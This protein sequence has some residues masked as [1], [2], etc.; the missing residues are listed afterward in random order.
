M[1]KE[2]N[3]YAIQYHKRDNKEKSGHEIYLAKNSEQDRKMFKRDFGK[4]LVIQ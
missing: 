2:L 3:S 4:S 1:K